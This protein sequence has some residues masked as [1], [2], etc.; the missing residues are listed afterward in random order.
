MSEISVAALQRYLTQLFKDD[1]KIISVGAIGKKPKDALK[2]YGYGAPLR[3]DLAIDGARRSVVF[4]TVKPGGFGHEGMADRAAI[5]LWESRAFNALPRHV[6]ALD[7]GAL[8]RDGSA[9]TLGDCVELFLLT[10]LVEGT[11]YHHDLDRIRDTGATSALDLR[12]CRALAEYLAEIHAVKH[13]DPG[14][15]ER[16]IRELIGHN[17]CILGLTDSYPTDLDYIGPT[18][19]AWIEK[20]CIDWRWRIKSL[21]R[22]LSQVHG[23]FHPWNVL[24]REETDFTVLDRSRGEWGEPADDVAAMTINYLFYALQHRGALDGPFKT[25]WDAFFDAYLTATGDIELLEVVQPFLCWRALVIASPVWY[26]DLSLDVRTKLLNLAKN[27]LE[28]TVLDPAHT[29]SLL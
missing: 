21:A 1:V 14:L 25:L 22:R 17:E 26:P 5:L 23:D 7:V 29:D 16:R 27:V 12:R 24:F 3:I 15:Y 13:S 10:E 20:R 9:K 4:S 28:T 18:Q 11:E 2:A 6:R 8:T 19:L